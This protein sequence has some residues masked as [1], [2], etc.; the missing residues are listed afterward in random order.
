VSPKSSSAGRGESRENYLGLDGA[1]QPSRPEGL[2]RVVAKAGYGSRAQAEAMVQAGRVTVDGQAVVD[3]AL[4]VDATS[5]ITL[6]GRQLVEAPRRYFAFH[7]PAQIN[8]KQGGGKDPVE[9][10]L[11]QLSAGVPGLEPIGRL[12]PRTSGLVLIANDHWWKAAILNR[13]R[14]EREFVVTVQGELGDTEVG[15]ML[16]GVH[17]QGLGQVRPIEVRVLARDAEA[18]RLRLAL[19]GAKI[20]QVRGLFQALRHDLLDLAVVRIGVVRLAE[21]GPSQAR[22]LTAAE[23]QAMRLG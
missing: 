20:R 18:T 6:D 15:I 21:L 7:K 12:D 3:P 4:A 17:L 1:W 22:P 11:P 5:R 14:L 8:T 16:G 19:R 10:I 13:R 9:V 2:A 23:V